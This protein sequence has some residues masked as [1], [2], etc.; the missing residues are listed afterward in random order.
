MEKE[1]RSSFD[2]STSSLLRTNGFNGVSST[3]LIPHLE[4]QQHGD[5]DER[6]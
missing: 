4:S 2:S 5:E 1:H 3:L 6:H